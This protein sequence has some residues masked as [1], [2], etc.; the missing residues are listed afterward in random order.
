M[1]GKQPAADGGFFTSGREVAFLTGVLG[2]AA[3]HFRWRGNT[4]MA[5]AQTAPEAPRNLQ[6]A[7]RAAQRNMVEA[8]QALVKTAEAIDKALTM[9]PEDPAAQLDVLALETAVDAFADYCAVHERGTAIYQSLL[10]QTLMAASPRG[11]A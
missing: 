4:L 8:G 5:F 11:R 9:T 10:E 7:V 3:E 6:G 1:A 2:A